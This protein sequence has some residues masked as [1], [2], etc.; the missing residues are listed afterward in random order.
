[1]NTSERATRW[2]LFLLL[3]VAFAYI[4]PRWADWSQ[5][6][7]M[8]LTLAIVDHGSL[9]I[10][11]YFGNTG[12]YAKFEGHYYSDKAPGPSFLGV[13][14]YAAFR[15]L[16]QSTPMQAILLRVSQT[17]AFQN[18]L[19]EAGSGLLIEKIEYFVALMVVTF[20][21]ISL[22]SAVM[23]L[24]LYDFLDL[25]GLQR[26]W[27]LIVVLAYALGTNTFS[28]SS[29]FFSHQLAAFCLFTAFYLAF[30]IH[31][32]LNHPAWSIAAGF[33]LGLAVI[34][35]YPAA[36]IALAVFIYMIYVLRKSTWTAAFIAAGVPPGALMM[37][38]NWAIYHT[39]LPVGYEYSELYTDVHSTGFLSI[40]YPQLSAL[41]GLTFGSFRGLFFSAPILLLGLAG[42][43]LWIKNGKNR[44][45][46]IVSAW[47]FLSMLLF[48][49]S[50]IMWN[51]GYSVG[52]RYLV[53]MQPFLAL[54]VGIAALYLGRKYWFKVVF[55]ILGL[56]S[57]LNIWIQTFG[58]QTFP[59]WTLNPLFNYSIPNILAGD[60]ARN[61]GMVL[62]L[63]GIFS[64]LP[65]ILLLI[66][67]VWVLFYFNSQPG[68]TAS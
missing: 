55:G 56:L 67:G 29:V 62:G 27:R 45:E 6:S 38:Y 30:R 7:R 52:P 14:V 57:L 41:W 63:R 59:D 32:K 18:T 9:S 2:L 49:G 34:S 33:L 46:A 39:P 4:F 60:I 48:Y 64:L 15:P 43:W 3:L 26:A 24:F 44:P 35:E 16:L 11:P 28:F 22:P 51:G 20:F 66:L 17:S 65:L 61:W 1:M 47:A 13:P 12:D 31:H 21:T 36:L 8:N 37:A 58:G 25:V 40:T 42:F 50:S 68:N 19:N 10:D 23:G 53:P 54:S 5:N